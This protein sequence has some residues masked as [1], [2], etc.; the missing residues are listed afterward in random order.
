MRAGVQ[1]DVPA[2]FPPVFTARNELSFIYFWGA[3]QAANFD[4][5]DYK[6]SDN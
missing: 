5:L 2:A 1:R 4:I 6:A 3:S